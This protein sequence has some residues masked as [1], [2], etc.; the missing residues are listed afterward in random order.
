MSSSPHAAPSKQKCGQNFN[1]RYS[2]AMD[3]GVVSESA[4]EGCDLIGDVMGKTV[5][6]R[7]EAS[8]LVRRFFD[9]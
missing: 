8:S 5:V 3:Y 4:T 7:I 1:I 6:A 9:N 2:L